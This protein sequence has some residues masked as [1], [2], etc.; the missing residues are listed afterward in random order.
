MVDQNKLTSTYSFTKRD[1]YYF[2]RR[3][4]EDLQRQYKRTRIVTSLKTKDAKEANTN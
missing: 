2:S 3:V 1:I 4:P